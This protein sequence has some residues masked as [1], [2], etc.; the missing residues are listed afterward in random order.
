[1]IKRETR[2]SK[3]LTIIKRSCVTG[4]AVW[5]YQGHSKDGA[6]CAYWRACK[7]EMTL[8]RNWRR[9]MAA[10]ADAIRGLLQDC[11]AALPII[12]E[13]NE[14]QRAAVKRLQTIADKAPEYYSGF[15]NHIRT[16]R[17]R[18]AKD[19]EIRRQMREREKDENPCY[20]KQEGRD[21]E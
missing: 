17:R 13:L 2:K 14:A 15:Y 7:R 10:R 19:R 5:L 6:K 11:L 16:E 8:E 4:K 21:E 1:M 3:I 12:G 20:D 9:L 18:R